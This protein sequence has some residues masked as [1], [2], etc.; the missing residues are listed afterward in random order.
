MPK[1]YMGDYDIDRLLYLAEN[2]NPDAIY[3]IACRQLTGTDIE[4][5]PEAAYENFCILS[6]NGDEDAEVQIAKMYCWGFFGENQIPKGQRFL[7]NAVEAENTVAYYEL[8]YIYE[9][10]IGCNVDLKK[11]SELYSE[12]AMAGF[13][14][15]K[16]AIKKFRQAAPS[17]KPMNSYSGINTSA[18]PK[19]SSY[20]STSNQSFSLGLDYFNRAIK[21]WDI[22]QG[23]IALSKHSINLS[24]VM[25]KSLSECLTNTHLSTIHFEDAIRNGKTEAHIYIAKM[26][27]FKYYLYSFV[28]SNI[29][30]E[31]MNLNALD[32]LDDLEKAK[33]HLTVATESGVDFELCQETC[34][35]CADRC[36]EHE[37]ISFVKAEKLEI[38]DYSI[39]IRMQEKFAIALAKSPVFKFARDFCKINRKNLELMAT[40]NNVLAQRKLGII[41]KK[42]D[43]LGIEWKAGE[44]WL[45][46]AAENGDPIAMMEYSDYLFGCFGGTKNVKNALALLERA[47][48]SGKAECVC[49]LAEALAKGLGS[50]QG[51]YDLKR[52]LL[53]YEQ[54]CSK[55]VAQA[56]YELAD[57]CEDS[58]MKKYRKNYNP[59][60]LY[61]RASS[62]GYDRATRALVKNYGYSASSKE[63]NQLIIREVK[64]DVVFA[65]P[66][67][68]CRSGLRSPLKKFL[69]VY[70]NQCP[71][72]NGKWKWVGSTKVKL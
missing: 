22:L 33:H 16:R 62:L 63:L 46:K 61:Q 54:M 2:G 53:L 59:K 35:F 14:P 47:A 4:Q 19:T 9:H 57:F 69:G 29:H 1:I 68:H 30:I 51:S 49:S 66:C 15:A 20:K 58:R 70:Y 32:A 13:L 38:T 64:K 39:S 25:V 60:Q 28:N 10:G 71:M 36:F 65:G 50:Q 37:F 41:L 67:P 40:S 45:K 24:D 26:Y 23:A 56:M 11:A 3:E 72:C 6:E 55:G 18:A 8:A 21:F 7:I 12:A 34:E 52:A 48:D 17:N 44:A 31:G 42:G 27:T 43:Y 5:D